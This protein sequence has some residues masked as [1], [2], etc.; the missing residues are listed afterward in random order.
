MR[1]KLRSSKLRLAVLVLVSVVSSGCSALAGNQ[2]SP[3][4]P[5][6]PKPTA[7]KAVEC[8]IDEK[9][10]QT[11]VITPWA[12]YDAMNVELRAACVALGHSLKD[13]DIRLEEKDEK[14]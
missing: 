13:C 5:T 8:T 4:K 10:G 2:S 7:A 3:Y 6:I 12:Y 11:C 14:E 9:P 1:E